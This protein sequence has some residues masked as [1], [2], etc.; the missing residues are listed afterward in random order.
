M[1]PR[2]KLAREISRALEENE[3]TADAG[4]SVVDDGGVITL[5]GVVETYEIREAAESIAESFDEVVEVVNDLSVE[6]ELEEDDEYLGE[7]PYEDDDFFED[8]ADDELYDD[9]DY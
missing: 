7:E 3:L 1:A 5:K 6:E 9:P 8:D 4:I 2:T